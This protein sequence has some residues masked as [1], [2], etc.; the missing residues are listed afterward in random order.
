M[1]NRFRYLNIGIGLILAFVGLKML[2]SQLFHLPTW[3]SLAVIAGVISTSVLASLYADWRD[4]Q[5]TRPTS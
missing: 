3:V 5:S 2:G 1:A 4:A